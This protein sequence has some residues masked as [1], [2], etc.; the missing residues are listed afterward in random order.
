MHLFL[1]QTWKR[2]AVSARGQLCQAGMGDKLDPFFLAGQWGLGQKFSDTFPKVPGFIARLSGLFAF[3]PFELP[4]FSVG[5]SKLTLWG[6]SHLVSKC[7]LLGASAGV[8]GER[9]PSCRARS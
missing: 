3:S 4:S 6:R 7:R 8:G 1:Q 9:S 2:A 5:T